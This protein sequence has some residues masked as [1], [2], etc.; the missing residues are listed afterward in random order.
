MKNFMKLTFGIAALALGVASAASSYSLKLYDSVWIGTTQ[1]K[2]GE[3]KVEM[4]ADKAVFKLGKSV[5]EVP[6][7]FAK[8]DRK[9]SATSFVS[10]GAKVVEIDLGGT[11]DKI[12]FS[13]APGA[14]SA[15]GSK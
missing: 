9:Y 15:G 13:S 7:T 1:L 11:M 5:V 8:N 12:L 2:A 4:Q 6:A 14:Q 10:E 3:Y